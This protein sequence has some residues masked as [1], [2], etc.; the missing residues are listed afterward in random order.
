MKAS[1]LGIPVLTKNLC[2]TLRKNEIPLLVLCNLVLLY[3]IPYT[4]RFR[5]FRS[6]E[7]VEYGLKFKYA[8]LASSVPG[9]PNPAHRNRS[10]NSIL[11]LFEK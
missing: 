1:P 5:F 8:A 9:K 7:F 6:L 11:S 10:L 3:I 2:R 4:V